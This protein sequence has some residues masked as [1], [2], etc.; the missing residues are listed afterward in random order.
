MVASRGIVNIIPGPGV[1]IGALELIVV[2]TAILDRVTVVGR[3][4]AVAKILSAVV[5]L[6]VVPMEDQ[7]PLG[8][9]ANKSLGH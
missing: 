6:I 9:R 3:M 5:I 2:T 8:A 7:G 4:I 1:P